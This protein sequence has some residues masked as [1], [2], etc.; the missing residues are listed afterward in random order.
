MRAV[1]IVDNLFEDLQSSVAAESLIET[2]GK[3][4][5]SLWMRGDELRCMVNAWDGMV[6][7]EQP[8]A[9]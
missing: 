1:R 3:E 6:W 2:S 5:V 8:R 4:F 9:G 7:N